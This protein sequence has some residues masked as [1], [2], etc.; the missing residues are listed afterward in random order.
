MEIKEGLNTPY[1]KL[2]KEN[3]VLT[4]VGKS[5]P[6][7]SESF[8]TPIVKEVEECR[9]SLTNSKIT[10]NISLEILN[11]IS[12]KS[13][14]QIIK[15]LYEYSMG[16]EVNWYYEEDDENMLEEG[17]DLKELLPKAKFNL[18]SVKDLRKVEG[19]T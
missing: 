14:F 19:L 9:E 6:D 3:C 7:H 13:L 16:T 17:C 8:Y 18:I 12:T 2:D 11:S 1:V 4:F 15:D 10:I 5:Y